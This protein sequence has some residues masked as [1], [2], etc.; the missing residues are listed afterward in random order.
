MLPRDSDPKSQEGGKQ[1]WSR[2]AV[3]QGRRVQFR[4]SMDVLDD[5]TGVAGIAWQH[6]RW[7]SRKWSRLL[8]NWCGVQCEEPNHEF[9]Q[10]SVSVK[11]DWR[12]YNSSMLVETKFE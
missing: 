1:A 8:E 9:E 7:D 2:L 10:F 5:L 4:S 3:A 11:L 12:M 6:G